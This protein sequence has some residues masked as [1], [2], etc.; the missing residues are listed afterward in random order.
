MVD[1]LLY[2]EKTVLGLM[3][4][5]SHIRCVK[6]YFQ[7]NSRIAYEKNST[8]FFILLEKINGKIHL[9]VDFL[10][11]YYYPVDFWITLLSSIFYIDCLKNS[12]TENY[13]VTKTVDF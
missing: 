7:K 4:D 1:K 9:S 8:V 11:L 13:T 5:N 3:G 6:I 12:K 2:G 10:L